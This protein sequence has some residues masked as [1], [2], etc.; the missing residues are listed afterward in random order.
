MD[1]IQKSWEIK[2]P[3]S[4]KIEI[5]NKIMLV[6]EDLLFGLVFNILWSLVFVNLW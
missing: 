1:I 6:I 4:C 3:I 2:G 5:E